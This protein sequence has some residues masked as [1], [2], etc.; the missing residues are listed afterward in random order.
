[1]NMA[2][3]R[4]T[5]GSG[6]FACSSCGKQTRNTGD[7][8]GCGVCPLCYEIG[9]ME[10]ELSD[11]GWG[12]HGDLEGCKTVAE[13][14]AKFE[15][16]RIKAETAKADKV[17]VTTASAESAL[18]AACDIRE[19]DPMTYHGP[20]AGVSDGYPVKVTLSMGQLRA[21]NAAIAKAKG[22]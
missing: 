1:M 10:N 22:N 7:N 20:N 18:L 12:K 9:G 14:E 21:I 16:I 5:K 2:T 11:N 19:L 8:G 17:N 3:T 15:A 4:F 13:A 6:C